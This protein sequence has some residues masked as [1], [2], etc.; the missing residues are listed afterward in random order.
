MRKVYPSARYFIQH[1]YKG[2]SGR[3]LVTRSQ[4]KSYFN[5]ERMNRVFTNDVSMQLNIETLLHKSF[6]KKQVSLTTVLKQSKYGA[7]ELF[8][9]SNSMGFTKISE[10]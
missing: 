9:Q 3:H 7:E 4:D 5:R 2:A 1:A 6:P 8:L 10:I